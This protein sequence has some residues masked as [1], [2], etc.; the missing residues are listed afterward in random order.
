MDVI[1]GTSDGEVYIWSLDSNTL[2]N[3]IYIHARCLTTAC[4]IV[5]GER[6]IT[7]CEDGDMCIT[8]I[9]LSHSVSIFN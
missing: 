4:Y 9:N 8:D 5:S 3:R 1:S 2:L 6:V 7:T